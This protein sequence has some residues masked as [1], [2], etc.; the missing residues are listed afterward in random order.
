MP[1]LRYTN[2]WVL[3]LCYVNPTLYEKDPSWVEFVMMLSFFFYINLQISRLL[4]PA[5]VKHGA[6]ICL[7]EWL[8]N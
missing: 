7:V 2:D 5:N 4:S 3:T 6:F 1:E 8:F